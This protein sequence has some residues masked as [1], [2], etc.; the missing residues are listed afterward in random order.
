MKREQC[1]YCG[2]TL[3]HKKIVYD[4][5]VGEKHL[6]F[7]EVPASVCSDCDAVWIDGKIAEKMEQIFNNGQKPTR[8]AKIPVWSFPKAA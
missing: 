1:A 4:K 7:E 3:L 5:K 8:W 6:L 2:G